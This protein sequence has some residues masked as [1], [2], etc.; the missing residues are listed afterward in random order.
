MHDMKTAALWVAPGLRAASPHIGAF[1]PDFTLSDGP[2]GATRL[3]TWDEGPWAA[4]A[5][6]GRRRPVAL[7][8]PGLPPVRP[9]NGLSDALTH[10]RFADPFTGLPC[11]PARAEEEIGRAHV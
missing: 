11:T 1:F 9:P 7:V 4:P 2:E 3:E 8:A 10:T 6:N 5:F